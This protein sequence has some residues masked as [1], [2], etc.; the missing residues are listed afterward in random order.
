MPLPSTD[1]AAIRGKI[2]LNSAGPVSKEGV[3]ALFDALAPATDPETGDVTLGHTQRD[4][5]GRTYMRVKAEGTVAGEGEVG[6]IDPAT[7]DFTLLSTSN[8][9]AG[10]IVAVA[11]EA[12]ADEEDLWVVVDGPT[13]IQVGANAAAQVALNTTATAG[14][15]DDDATGGA[16]VVNNLWLTAARGGTAGTAAGMARNPRL[17]LAAI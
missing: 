3:L 17:A 8:D 16:F 15:L 9:A 1:F 2:N 13:L 10:L 11:Q 4:P 6:F 7:F 14:Q 5:D 12:A